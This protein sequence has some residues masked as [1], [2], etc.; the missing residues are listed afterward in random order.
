MLA[1]S[2]IIYVIR[3]MENKKI[4]MLLWFPS[5][6]SFDNGLLT[7]DLGTPIKDCEFLRP[8]VVYQMVSGYFTA[9]SY[10]VPSGKLT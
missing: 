2:C 9:I 5:Y 1:D 4:A 8:V 3:A 6:I 10:F 7:V